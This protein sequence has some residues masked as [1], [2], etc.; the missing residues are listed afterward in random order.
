MAKVT[1]EEYDRSLAESQQLVADIE[2]MQANKPWQA[3]IVDDDTEYPLSQANE[4]PKDNLRKSLLA[5]LTPIEGGATNKLVKTPQAQSLRKDAPPFFDEEGLSPFSTTEQQ[6]Q[7]PATTRPD[8]TPRYEGPPIDPR[9]NRPFGDVPEEEIQKEMLE[10]LSAKLSVGNF[11]MDDKW[12]RVLAKSVPEIAQHYPNILE[13]MNVHYQYIKEAMEAHRLMYEITGPDDEEGIKRAVEARDKSMQT[14]QQLPLE[15]PMNGIV[16]ETLRAMA[17]TGASFVDIAKDAGPGAAVVVGMGAVAGGLAGGLTGAPGQGALWGAKTAMKFGVPI[18]MFESMQRQ[19]TGEFL[20]D[21]MAPIE[22]GQEPIPYAIA[23]PIAEKYAVPY[24]ILE[25]TGKIAEVIAGFGFTATISKRVVALAAEGGTEWGQTLIQQIGLWAAQKEFAR[26]KNSPFDVK[27]EDILDYHEAK[28]AARLAILGTGGISIATSPIT[29]PFATKRM[30]TEYNRR[31]TF[32]EIRRDLKRLEDYN[33]KILDDN[34]DKPID[35]VTDE[36]TNTLVTGE[37]IDPAEIGDVANEP[38]LAGTDITDDKIDDLVV[39]DDADLDDALDAI[40]SGIEDSYDDVTA[41]FFT[42]MREHFKDEEHVGMV[43]GL[44]TARAQAEGMSLSQYM[45]KRGLTFEKIN[46]DADMVGAYTYFSEEGN[47]IITAFN[48]AN[49]VDVIS[50]LGH[51]FRMDLDEKQQAIMDKF[52]GV[53]IG[54]EW[55]GAANE[56]FSQGWEQYLATGEAPSHE[57]KGLF[58]KLNSWITKIYKTI[59]KM[60]VPN[61]DIPPEMMEVYDSLLVKKTVADGNATSVNDAKADSKL[62]KPTIEEPPEDITTTDDI[63]EPPEI[64]EDDIIDETPEPPTIDEEDIVETPKEPKKKKIV[65]R[66]KINTRGISGFGSTTQSEADYTPTGMRGERDIFDDITGDENSAAD[67]A[68]WYIDNGDQEQQIIANRIIGLLRDIPFTVVELNTHYDNNVPTDMENALGLYVPDEQTQRAAVFVRGKSWGDRAA[69]NETPLHELVHAAT[70]MRIYEAR[71]LIAQGV[72]NTLTRNYIALETFRDQLSALVKSQYQAGAQT[73]NHT[74]SMDMPISGFKKD[75]ELIAYGM[76][77]RSFQEWLATVNMRMIDAHG[78]SKPV[79][80]ITKF[81]RVIR[82]LL[83]IPASEETALIRV[84]QFGEIFMRTQKEHTAKQK[85][86]STA[87]G[88]KKTDQVEWEGEATNTLVEAEKAEKARKE[89]TADALVERIK[90]EREARERAMAA[91]DA[92]IASKIKAGTTAK[93]AARIQQKA[94]VRAMKALFDA[95]DLHGYRVAR[96]HFKAILARERAKAAAVAKHKA[97]RK[98]IMTK[99]EKGMPS[100]IH[101]KLYVKISPEMSKLF[102]DVLKVLHPLKTNKQIRELYDIRMGGQ[103]DAYAMA[104]T[105]ADYIINTFLDGAVSRNASGVRILENLNEAL[106]LLLSGESQLSPMMKKKAEIDRM[107][108][109]IINSINGG[110]V[111]DSPLTDTKLLHEQRKKQKT[112]REYWATWTVGHKN[113]FGLTGLIKLATSYTPGSQSALSKMC[114][115][116]EAKQ[117]KMTR[118]REE[119]AKIMEMYIRSFGLDNKKTKYALFKKW[120]EDTKPVHRIAGVDMGKAQ[121]RQIWM[122]MQDPTL[123]NR[124]VMQFMDPKD[125]AKVKKDLTDEEIDEIEAA[126]LENYDNI[127]NQVNEILTDED[128]AFAQLLMGYF[129]SDEQYEYVNRVHKIVAGLELGR[130]EGYVPIRA[131]NYLNITEQLDRGHEA[132][133][134][135][136]DDY[137][138]KTPQSAKSIRERAKNA[139]RFQMRFDGDITLFNSYTE[140]M[141]HYVNFAEQAQLV[142]IAIEDKDIR[143]AIEVEYGRDVYNSIVSAVEDVLADGIHNQKQYPLMDKFRATFVRSTIGMA[144][145]VFL[146]QHISIV[147]YAQHMPVL[148]FTKGMAVFWKNPIDNFS[149]MMD[150][151]FIKNRK[152]SM[153]RD[154]KQTATSAEYKRWR[155]NPTLSNLITLNVTLGDSSAIIQGAWVYKEYLKTQTNPATGK[156]YTNKEALAEAFNKSNATQQSGDMQELSWTQRG[157]SAMQLMTM[158]STGPIQAL[159]QEIE[160]VRDYAA[161][162]I[163]KAQL[164]KTLAI[165]HVIVPSMFA[166]VSGLMTGREEDDWLKAQLLAAALGPFSA[167][168]GV[169]EVISNVTSGLLGMRVYPAEGLLSD[170]IYGTYK[171]LKDWTTGE[172]LS[173]ED[174]SKLFQ[175]IM[176]FTGHGVPTT[177]ITRVGENLAEGNVTGALLQQRVEE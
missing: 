138:R 40:D 128:K 136:H 110:N 159:R 165:Y 62:N 47:T 70:C 116:F 166:M 108:P 44:I 30:L 6:E 104:K 54:S 68:Q 50:E 93:V 48:N 7:A 132:S 149:E 20:L 56:T 43:E 4:P 162:N 13:V 49:I 169:G 34:K 126:A 14:R 141:A 86:A 122:Y 152:N 103:F 45:E 57:L 79:R 15:Y 177:R 160:A 105:D 58:Q 76:T 158:Y 144:T 142:K 172:D 53:D 80:A 31:K 171:F 146:K 113:V 107:R 26:V 109:E 87:S 98:S 1:Q 55:D 134:F 92:A 100:K 82:A 117:R 72:D 139:D 133:Q 112:R 119:Q 8:F 150:T 18:K 59:R 22:E 19:G 101:G 77:S 155:L 78:M 123:T 148:D 33:K 9:T 73:G 163:S 157:G 11:D 114:N 168:Y 99:L 115:F 75:T 67:V 106:A 140:E 84:M 176:M 38:I 16:H 39:T 147:Q 42:G 143:R 25:T 156:K 129:N 29:I 71:D 12:A 175:S 131:E 69:S 153:D 111:V 27:V 61:L 3:G 37:P 121:V 74:I 170:A 124:L 167:I 28:L 63:E 81:V 130:I 164:L 90:K 94:M 96:D 2:N 24:A 145:S 36:A 10:A 32:N 154:M 161:G 60:D 88:I 64:G 17:E 35:D 95:G 97:L 118:I 135:K 120:A 102:R 46:T 125:R 174:W 89:P 173:I 127:V 65:K 5:P 91:Y 51:V 151:D 41:A 83:G 137:I 52:V 23:R 21:M 85:A 66:F